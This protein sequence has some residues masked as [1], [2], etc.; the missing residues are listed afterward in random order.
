MDLIEKLECL[1]PCF[2]M[3]SE[4]G[5]TI[6]RAIEWLKLNEQTEKKLNYRV[7]TLKQTQIKQLNIIQEQENRIDKAIKKLD[8]LNSIAPPYTIDIEEIIEILKG[9]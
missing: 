2:G 6:I 5:K 3:N 9:E 7:K 8:K 1:I 4:G